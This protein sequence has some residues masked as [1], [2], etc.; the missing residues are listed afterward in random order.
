[1]NRILV[2]LKK[3]GLDVLVQPGASGFVKGVHI[4]NGALHVDTAV[5]TPSN[6]LHEAGHIAIVPVKYRDTISN[7]ISAGVSMMLEDIASRDIHPDHPLYRA[8]MQCGDTEATAW[9]YAAGIHLGLDPE[10][11]I[12]DRDYNGDGANVR[13]M[14]GN[15]HYFGVHGLAHAGFCSLNTRS[16]K[17]TGLPSYPKLSMW[18]QNA[19]FTNPITINNRT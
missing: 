9:A 2:F 15:G 8:A 17:L 16:E 11:I 18:L 4:V 19:E 6:I 14:V 3:I 10:V 13:F 1:M 7:D 5:A 12:E